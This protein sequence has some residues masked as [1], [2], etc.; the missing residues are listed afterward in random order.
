MVDP[1]TSALRE[2]RSTLSYAGVEWCRRRGSNSRPWLYKN[3]ALPLCYAGMKIHKRA[4]L[5]HPIEIPH[6]RKPAQRLTEEDRYRSV[7]RLMS[8]GGRSCRNQ[9]TSSRSSS[10]PA[11]VRRMRSADVIE[12]WFAGAGFAETAVLLHAVHEGERNRRGENP[13]ACA[14]L[15]SCGGVGAGHRALR[16]FGRGWIPAACYALAAILSPDRSRD[17]G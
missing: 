12:G 17:F 13:L 16:L 9:I 1:P 14:V 4:A 10:F 11:T 3:P 7:G 6:C 15:E 2:R 5:G 8:R